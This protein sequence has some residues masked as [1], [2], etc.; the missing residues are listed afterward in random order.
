[1]ILIDVN[2]S[3]YKPYMLSYETTT[4]VSRCLISRLVHFY[5][6]ISDVLQRYNSGYGDRERW[7]IGKL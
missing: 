3:L 2:K 6:Y 4:L 7:Y 1:M 5:V